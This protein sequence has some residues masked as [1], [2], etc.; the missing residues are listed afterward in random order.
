MRTRNFRVRNEV[1]E[2]GVKKGKKAYVD[3][4]VGECF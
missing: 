2:I 3:W 1:V 4:K